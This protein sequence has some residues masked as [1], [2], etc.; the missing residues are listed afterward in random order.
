MNYKKNFTQI[1]IL[2]FLAVI[3]AIAI[4]FVFFTEGNEKE[5]E[6]EYVSPQPTE[7]IN[8]GNRTNEEEDK[9]IQ[10]AI[11]DATLGDSTNITIPNSSEKEE[12]PVMTQETWDQYYKEMVRLVQGKNI[13]GFRI[14]CNQIYYGYKIENEDW[15]NLVY[16]G[17]MAGDFLIDIGT[18][19]TYMSLIN[20]HTIYVLLFCQMDTIEHS[21]YLPRLNMQALPNGSINNCTIIA[22]DPDGGSYYSEAYR[23]FS[24]WDNT[25][26]YKIT[27]EYDDGSKYDI[28]YAENREV[29][30]GL[31][32]NI[33]RTETQDV[34]T[35][36]EDYFNFLGIDPTELI[37]DGI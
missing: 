24:D 11:Q 19:Q 27:V 23:Y 4:I 25:T 26:V 14:L 7:Q 13:E 9:F 32:T 10:D 3:I 20:D 37:Y 6:K 33:L 31:I 22:E 16:A 36:Y 15:Y 28:F 17:T 12:Q 35:S 5:P 21:A 29:D 30:Y 34:E 2:G 18:R 1:A 8:M